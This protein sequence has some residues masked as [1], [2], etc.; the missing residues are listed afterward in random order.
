MNY[1]RK[2]CENFQV[3]SLNVV[4]S[5]EGRVPQIFYI[6]V[7]WEISFRFQCRGVGRSLYACFLWAMLKLIWRENK[8]K[9]HVCWK[10]KTN[11]LKNFSRDLASILDFLALLR[12]TQNS[13]LLG[14]RKCAYKGLN[15]IK[16]QKSDNSGCGMGGYPLSEYNRERVFRGGTPLQ[17]LKSHNLYIY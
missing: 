5:T 11:I 15:G 2:V 14:R 6:V 8:R 10:V 16:E 3:F 4:S 9:L 7:A 17:N 1:Y 12:N 13:A